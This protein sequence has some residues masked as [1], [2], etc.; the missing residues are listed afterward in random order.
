MPGQFLCRDQRGIV[1]LR[2]R[3]AEG[4]YLYGRVI[5]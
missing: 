4:K 2:E 3:V 5:R 1:E